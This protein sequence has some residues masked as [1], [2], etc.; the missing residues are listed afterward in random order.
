MGRGPRLQAIFHRQVKGDHALLAL[1]QRRFS[2]AGLGA[3]FYP[4][5]PE[6]LRDELRFLP[7]GDGRYTVHLPRHLRVLEGRDSHDRILAFATA[8]NAVG[9]VLHDQ[10]E[11]ED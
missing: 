2:E 5:A 7:A 4:N 11:V 1:A 8:E 9:L 6:D 3:E 10:P